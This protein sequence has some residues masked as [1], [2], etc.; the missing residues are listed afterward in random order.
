MVFV[1]VE[2]VLVWFLGIEGIWGEMM[3]DSSGIKI[4]VERR[5]RGGRFVGSDEGG[6]F[7]GE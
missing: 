1:K 6:F 2:V 5:E 7:N 3:S 4:M